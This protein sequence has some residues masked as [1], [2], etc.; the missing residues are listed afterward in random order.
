MACSGAFTLKP[1][2]AR[3]ASW[4]SPASAIPKAARATERA[5]V[6]RRCC[7][8]TCHF[9]RREICS[10]ATT[11]GRG[12]RI[13]KKHV[14][15]VPSPAQRSEAPQIGIYARPGELRP[16]EAS[17]PTS[18]SKHETIQNKESAMRYQLSI[19]IVLFLM[20]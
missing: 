17:G 2:S 11:N 6:G 20:L 1:A 7:R 15:R 4:L 14:G 10:L 13:G 8:K 3:T 19:I 18:A 16:D 5:N 12:Y 9:E